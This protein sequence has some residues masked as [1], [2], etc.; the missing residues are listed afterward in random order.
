MSYIVE[1]SEVQSRRPLSRSRRLLFD[2]QKQVRDRFGIVDFDPVVMLALIGVEAMYDR[3]K[4]DERG[5]PVLDQDGNQV[6]CPADRII[7]VA[8]L[9][10]CAGYVRPQLKSIEMG[11]EEAIETPV[12]DLESAKNKLAQ[13]LGLDQGKDVASCIEGFR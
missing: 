1:Q 5:N 7:A 6:I 8:A 11:L 13:S 9:S 4:T 3:P 12:E 2:M 10:K